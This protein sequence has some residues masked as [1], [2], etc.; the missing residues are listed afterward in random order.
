[1]I[2]A[3]SSPPS[4]QT[5]V[6][7]AHARAQ[8]VG[9]HAQELVADAVAVDVVDALEVVDVEHQQRDGR[10]RP[11]RILQRSAGAARGSSGG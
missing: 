8:R 11:A 10:V 3:N 1:M 2:T 5:I 4:R 9:E 6:V 7:G